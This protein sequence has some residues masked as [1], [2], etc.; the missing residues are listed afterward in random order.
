MVFQLVEN[1]IFEW[2][3]IEQS[4]IKLSIT[5][6]FI[7]EIATMSQLQSPILIFQAF[8]LLIFP[9]TLLD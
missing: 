5:E 8:I 2:V 1:A 6:H 9:K 4:I 3:I 7:S